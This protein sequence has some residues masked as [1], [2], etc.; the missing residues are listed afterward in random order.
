MD[1]I[2]EWKIKNFKYEKKTNRNFKWKKG[3]KNK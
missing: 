2:E 1:K 3:L